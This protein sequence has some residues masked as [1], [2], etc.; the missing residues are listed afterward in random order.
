MSYIGHLNNL[1]RIKNKN[2][3][4]LSND[5]DIS[6][7][8]L[9]EN[10]NVGI[11]FKEN[12]WEIV[13]KNYFTRVNNNYFSIS[14]STLLKKS[15]IY[16]VDSSED[17]LFLM[18]PDD[19]QLGDVIN[20]IDY[21]E[22]FDKNNVIVN[23]YCL[24]IKNTNVLFIH[25]GTQWI[26]IPNLMIL[27]SNLVFISKLYNNNPYKNLP[28]SINKEGQILYILNEIDISVDWV[29]IQNVPD[30]VF[31]VKIIPGNGLT[32]CENVIKLQLKNYNVKLLDLY[33]IE[34]DIRFFIRK[35]FADSRRI[36]KKMKVFMTGFLR[37]C[38]NVLLKLSDVEIDDLIMWDGNKW[39]GDKLRPIIS[40][41]L[42]NGISITPFS[43]NKKGQVTDIF[44][45]VNFTPE[46]LNIR[47]RPTTVKGYEFDTYTRNEIDGLVENNIKTKNFI[48][49]CNY[50]YYIDCA[51]RNITINNPP[52]P[53]EGDIVYFIDISEKTSNVIRINDVV[54][55]KTLKIIFINNEW[56][57]YV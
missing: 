21:R 26:L 48:P 8:R 33:H 43:V 25:D 29:D 55:N 38:D 36:F 19:G 32:T 54:L 42:V 2:L 41:R 7:L 4:T 12:C 3:V 20:V 11:F 45:N 44:D 22:T 49:R 50:V 6:G 31:E 9:T 34:F 27:L 16:F 57:T 56:S 47:N 13:A 14:K 37:E 1:L 40:E 46:W 18:L 24:D 53:K 39:T 28:F 51:F 23:Y 35:V 17:E 10:T 15:S 5:D 30:I 52:N